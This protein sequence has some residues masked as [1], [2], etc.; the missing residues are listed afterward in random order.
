MNP[1]PM[2]TVPNVVFEQYFW[3][4]IAPGKLRFPDTFRGEQLR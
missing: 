4:R 2:E 1:S 3:R